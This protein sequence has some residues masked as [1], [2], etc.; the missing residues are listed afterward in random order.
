MEWLRFEGL[1]RNYGAQDVFEG[2]SGTLRESETVGLVGA[3][4]A[5]KSSLLRI[6]AGVD[7][8]DAGTLVRARGTRF[9]YLAQDASDDA[10]TTLGGLVRGAFE[11]LH[12]EEARVRSLER[13]L[14]AAA[15][16]GDHVREAKLLHAYGEAREAFDRRGGDRGESR[17]RAM[18]AAFGFS[19]TDLERSTSEFSGGQRT[20]AML[21][22]VL[23]EDPDVLL[24]DEPTNHLDIET[25][26]WLEDFLLD[27]PRPC[28]LISHDRYVLERVATQIWDLERGMLVAY[29]TR[30]GFAYD[31]YRAQKAVREE[32]ARRVYEAARTEDARQRAVIAELRTHGSHNYSHVRSREKALAKL[33]VPQAPPASGPRTIGV[34]LEATRRATSGLALRV[35]KLAKAYDRDLFSNLSFELQRGG[36]LAVIGENGSGKSTLLRILAGFTPSDAGTVQVMDG[37]RLAYF[38]QESEA[39]LPRGR[40]AVEAVLET[41]VVPETARAL[42]GRMGLGGEAAD[43]PVESF[44]GGERRR[45]MLARLMARA[46]DCLLLDE[47]TNDL[48]IHSR[49]ALED[50]LAAY[51]G[52]TIVVS[53]DRYLLRRIGD[54]A[55]WLHDGTASWIEDGYEAYEA[56]RRPGGVPST[57]PKT[58]ARPRLAEPELDERA[59]R[60]GA[61][62]E[63]ADTES[64][65]ARLDARRAELQVEFAD[66]AIYGDRERVAA[67]EAELR[68]TEAA[69]EVALARW[70]SLLAWAEAP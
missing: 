40:S 62:R 66:P 58:V 1:R 16:A 38:S 13:D 33:V 34:R 15:E 29:P 36:R 20:R 11:R 56:M 48:D 5:G 68:A 65:V 41:G 53:H 35:G 46:S 14:A 69:A 9:G 17:T 59:R 37:V 30:P 61:E 43:K 67:L 25:V 24:L 70:E 39:E 55:L 26:R 60:R 19:T 6:L 28:I 50:V 18:L 7:E 47:P 2:L 27:D 12:A 4:G 44:S 23:L 10:G 22:R 64:E 8:P 57:T 51:E 52:A 21:A 42:L 31:D 3:N 54:R 45:I 49:E 63:L 32:E